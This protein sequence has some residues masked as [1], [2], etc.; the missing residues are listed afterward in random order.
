MTNNVPKCDITHIK[1]VKEHTITI[2]NTI[3]RT[4]K[5]T[6]DEIKYI[7]SNFKKLTIDSVEDLNFCVVERGYTWS[8][9]MF[10]NDKR[11]NRNWLNQSI[12]VLDFDDGMTPKEVLKR[13]KSYDIKP[14][15][16]YS[17]FSD[18]KELR[19]F[20]LI[21]FLDKTITIKKE[22]KFIQRGLMLMFP[23]CDMA[24]KDY[25]RM[26]YGG[27]KT[28]YKNEKLI[29]YS[30]LIDILNTFIISKNDNNHKLNGICKK[31]V[32][33]QYTITDNKKLVNNITP[34]LNFKFENC[35]KKIKILK[36]FINGKWLYHNQL[37]GLATNLLYIN[38][39]LK[40]MKE[41]M[42]KHTLDPNLKTHYND[43]N[44]AILPYIRN[45]KYL[46]MDLKNF[47]PYKEDPKYKNIP[48]YD[49]WKTGR[50]KKLNNK[51]IKKLTLME[52]ENMLS[53]KFEEVVKAKD[54]SVYLFRVET[55]LGKTKLLETMD[56]ALLAFPTHKLKSEV[57]NRMKI[58]CVYTPSFPIFKTEK[59]NEMI[60]AFYEDGLTKEVNLLLDKLSYRKSITYNKQKI[61]CHPD[62]AVLATQFS[63]DLEKCYGYDGT[64]LTTHKRAMFWK[65]HDT[66][67]FDEDPLQDILIIDKIQTKDITAFLDTKFDFTF[68]EIYRW[69]Q[70]IALKNCIE[71][72]KKF[73]IDYN[74]LVKLASIKKKNKVLKFL[75]SKFIYIPPK[76][77]E[78]IY[79]ISKNTLPEDKKIIIM[80]ATAPVFVYK[81]MFGDRLKVVKI[82][83]IE[84][85]GKIIQL[86]KHSCSRIGLNSYGET[87]A[88]L[89]SDKPVIT[90]KTHKHLF[91]N[92][93]DE[94]HF[95][96]CSG[97]DN[98]T[99]KDIAVVGTD[100]KPN[101]LYYF[102]AE[103][104]N[105]DYTTAD[106]LKTTKYQ[107]IEYNGFKFKFNTFENEDLK[108]IQ[109]SI[110]ESELT[111][112]VGRNRTLRNN[113]ETHLYSNLPLKI[114]DKFIY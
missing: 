4:T 34:V 58:D 33:N 91:E 45:R 39:G 110:I 36:H 25:A 1:K 37:F 73:P 56:N 48:Y 79:Y 55:G 24:C 97:Y 30:K 5:P 95:G 93:I 38:G 109:L 67:V 3:E 59:I 6:F 27:K 64:V 16:L 44:F 20:R 81:K 68:R 14:N 75:R 50:I 57:Y 94:L 9:A 21:L 61:N 52:A 18:S 31:V 114:S 42:L 84:K 104:L 49:Y 11:N 87:I 102:Y 43:N 78:T 71:P 62:D 60:K 70:K 46:P 19:K 66:I 63:E 15:L 74:E 7:H 108:N 77:P 72:M 13:L 80:S 101:F 41:L 54:N 107:L 98:L 89:V 99:G 32:K 2:D 26:Y 69:L 53:K 111:Q 8:P 51:P 106:A 88:K 10:K 96:N 65:N 83:Q 85:K 35:S 23:E 17:T 40:Y 76:S 22:S 12:F 82:E 92:S 29:N 90:F 47:S 86:T 112:A 113:C 28:I 105:V 103:V 100:H